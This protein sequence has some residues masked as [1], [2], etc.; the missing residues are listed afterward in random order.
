[1]QC[2]SGDSYWEGA[3]SLGGATF[4][5]SNNISPNNQLMP[6]DPGGP[7]TTPTQQQAAASTD[8][9]GLANLNLTAGALSTEVLSSTTATTFAAASSSETAPDIVVVTTNGQAVSTTFVPAT[10]SAYTALTAQTTVTT[11]GQNGFPTPLVI[12][13]GG[14]IWEL[15]EQQL[16]WRYHR[17]SFR[18]PKSL[19]TAGTLAKSHL[20][21]NKI[22]QPRHP[23]RL[24]QLHQPT[25]ATF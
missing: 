7:A 20:H 16:L 13:P 4:T 2:I 14:I 19:A 17:Q 21:R 11:T 3:W 5:I 24:R 18:L 25:L 9:A 12:W 23:H 8:G 22:L 1:M 6:Q 15:L 10:L